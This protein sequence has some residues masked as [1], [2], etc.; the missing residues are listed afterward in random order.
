VQIQ[1]ALQARHVRW[2]Q[3]RSLSD[4]FT[5]D[6]RS[7][8]GTPF[9]L[10]SHSINLRRFSPLAVLAVWAIATSIY[11]WMYA[12]ERVHSPDSV[13]YEAEWG[14]QFLMFAIVR[15]PFLLPLLAL[16][17]VWAIRRRRI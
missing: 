5:Y 13:G 9:T 11:A 3:I 14:F 8:I 15:L 17:M 2:R 12:S 16:L 6:G 1:R 7:V 4:L 10:P